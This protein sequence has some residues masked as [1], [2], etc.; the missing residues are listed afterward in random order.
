MLDDT[1]SNI[2]YKWLVL[3]EKNKSVAY[4]LKQLHYNK[5]AIYGDSELNER[6]I[7]ELTNEGIASNITKNISELFEYDCIIIADFQNYYKLEKLMPKNVDVVSIREI[8]EVTYFLF[9]DAKNISSLNKNTKKF[10]V[11]VPKVDVE[12][13]SK[14]IA[15]A[16]ASFIKFN[17]E[18][19][20]KNPSYFRYL[21][22]DIEEYGDE[23]IMQL[24]QTPA[25]IVKENGEATHIEYKSDYINIINGER[26][27]HNQPEEFYNRI[28]IFGDCYAFG[29]G[30]DD[31]RTIA[32]Y[33]QSYFRDSKVINYGM[34]GAGGE[35][36]C[37]ARPLYYSYNDND[38]IIIFSLYP[39]MPLSTKRRLFTYVEKELAN[40]GI[41][42]CDMANV[43]D[44]RDANMPMCYDSTHV[45]H[46]GYKI[47][48]EYLYNRYLSKININK[49]Y[50]ITNISA[51][52]VEANLSNDDNTGLQEYLKYLEKEKFKACS[53]KIY[54]SIVMNVNPFTYGHRY[55]IEQALKE[56]DYLYVFLVEEN[57]SIFSFEDRYNIITS[58]LK[59]LKNI[60]VL[61]SGRYIIS[62]VTFPEYF[63]KDFA[64]EVSVDTSLDISIFGAKIAPALNISVRFAGNE[65]FCN[66]TK[67]YNNAMR[68]LLPQY[69]IKFKEIQ[70]YEIDGMAV[71]ATTVRK[72][73]ESKDYKQLKKL[74]PE[75]TY[76]YLKEKFMI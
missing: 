76:N 37:F 71:S 30:T 58:N 65:P 43:Y 2:M 19:F 46:R 55:L 17:R 6:L 49:V 62:T 4:I 69:N 45:N 13:E 66:I 68:E 8:I 33:I 53:G 73:I 57:K 40:M 5:I 12:F 47:I 50:K 22:N 21:Y 3:R 29:T 64:K 36:R 11:R 70:R 38:I 14:N 59:D 39:Y 25:I 74:V 42:Y 26:Y 63:S 60:K 52:N 10:I 35:N 23:Y 61:R 75:A 20:D 9:V 18:V 41:V 7:N 16:M 54:G 34:L 67:Q 51:K 31:S 48:A 56:V 27:T 44:D 72:C 1:I 15:E 32:S 24:F 28:F